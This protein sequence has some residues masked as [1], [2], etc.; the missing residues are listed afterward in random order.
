MRTSSTLRKILIIVLT[1]V[2]FIACDV[3]ISYALVPYGTKS[4]VMWWEFRNTDQVD[5]IF[6]G[7]SLTQ[8]GLDPSVVDANYNSQSLNM[9]TNTQEPV[10]TYLALSEAFEHHD[11]KR[12]IYGFEIAMLTKQPRAAHLSG[13]LTEKWRG[14]GI[15]DMVS[16]AAY[17]IRGEQW[18]TSTDSLNIMFPWVKQHCSLFKVPRNIKSRLTCSNPGEAS[19]V[20]ENGWHYIGRGFGGHAKTFN[21]NRIDKKDYVSNHQPEKLRQ[22]QMDRLLE[23]CQLCKDNDVE[24]IL[25]VPPMP[26][27]NI[28]SLQDRYDKLFDEL[29]EQIA[30]YGVKCYDFNLAKD[31]LFDNHPED[32]M[33]WEHLNLR[34]AKRFSESLAKFLTY[35]DAGGDPANLFYDIDER[36]EHI[37]TIDYV[38]LKLTAEGGDSIKMTATPYTGPNTEVEYEF[39]A[40]EKDKG[41]FEVIQGYS[42][43]NE[44]TWKPGKKGAYE[45]RVYAR[46]ADTPVKYGTYHTKTI[47]L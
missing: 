39:R 1:L 17:A 24:L 32:Y 36:I 21:Y 6:I 9:A 23:V 7:D 11:I 10:E 35:K 18:L 8:R 44:L 16:D 41:V 30:P 33:D 12:V 31:E 14:D 29:D 27:F 38:K 37:D 45:V 43:K 22:E 5:T 13:F 2:V 3:L 40:R 26:E 20:N 4:E 28:V 47:V 46:Q 25:V 19:E 15:L 42:A 34:G